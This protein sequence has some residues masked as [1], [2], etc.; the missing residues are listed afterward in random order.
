M[1][2]K[3]LAV[4]PVPVWPVDNGHALR[5]AG[6][7]P[8]LCERWEVALAAPL[9]GPEAAAPAGWGLARFVP[10]RPQARWTFLPWQYDTAP[11]RAAVAGLAR[12]WQPRA[13]LLFGG[14]EYL[15]FDAAGFPPAVADHIDCL[16]LAVLAEARRAHGLRE[17]LGLLREVARLAGYERRVVR[18]MRA[19]AVVGERD[20]RAMR[21]LGGG[22]RVVVLP[23]GAEAQGDPGWKEAAR[24]PTAVFTGVLDYAPNADAAR[25]LAREIW[26]LVLRSVPAAR[27][28]I[29]GRRPGPEVL[30]L[31][32]A[33]SIAVVGDVS[34][35]TRELRA[36]WVAVAP[37]RTGSGIKNK[38]LEAWAAGRPVVMS[39]LAANGLDPP[40]ALAP[41]VEDG[42]GEIAARLV[43]VL[44]DGAERQALGEAALAH[45]RARHAW[46]D[47]AAQL[48]AL[49]AEA[50][51]PGAPLGPAG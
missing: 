47:V 15:A 46:S 9:A 13:A 6:V 14:A 25:W 21:R 1:R 32:A 30:A 50:A 12:D 34:D 20:A 49:L 44:T 19:T 40:P 48:S 4:S 38:V 33:P 7:L 29:V 22:G 17:R 41:L 42:A 31:A 26:P 28:R 37:M 8:G 18:R 16:T 11:V 43:R 35:M 36:A 39:R 10:L 5:V 2:E 51:G 27:L 45:V 3:L 24:E 23:N